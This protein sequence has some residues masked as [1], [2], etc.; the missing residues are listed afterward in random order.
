MADD[1][2]MERVEELEKAVESL[3]ELPQRMTTLDGRMGHLEGRVGSLELQIVQL[4]TEMKDGFSALRGEF[5]EV[6][7][8]GSRATEMLFKE[9]WALMRTLHEDVISRLARIGEAR[10]SGTS[11]PS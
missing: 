10:S 9:T 8:A 6:F 7:D 3:A 5:L 4:R 2:M 1:L 11:N